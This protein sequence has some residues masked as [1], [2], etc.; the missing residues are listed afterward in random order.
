[1]LGVSFLL[2][3]NA[4]AVDFPL[5]WRWSN[6][7]PHGGNVFDMDYAPLQSLGVQVCEN[8]QIYVSHDLDLWLPRDTFLTNFLRAVTFLG[9]RVIITGESGIV[10][11]SNDGESFQAGALAD[12]LTTDWLEAVTASASLAVAVGDNGAVYTSANG[13]T[14]K[15]Q[16][17]GTTANLRGVAAGAGFF[18][19]VGE[20]GNIRSSA[21]GTNWTARS[22]PTSAH[23][24][25]VGFGNS[26]FTSVGDGGVT[27]ASTNAGLTWFL[28]SPGATNDLQY[29][30]VGGTNRLLD[31]TSEVRVQDGG[32]WSNELAKTN[33]PPDWTY[34][35]A[36][37][38]PGFF[39]I[40]GRSGMQAEGYQT[41][42]DP[43]FWLTPHSSVRNWLWDVIRLPS[44]YA[45]V[46]DFGTIMTSGGGVDWTLE[47]PPSGV[48]DNTLLG[49]GGTTNLL[50]AVGDTGTIIYSPNTVTNIITTNSTGTVTQSMSTLGVVWYEA[51]SL[52]T[53]TLQ[54]VGV[55]NH[56]LLVVTGGRGTIRTSTDGLIWQVVTSPTTNL[57][58]GVAGW[59]NGLVAVG[60]NGTVLTSSDGKSWSQRS[61]GTTNWIY[62]VRWLNGTLVAVGQ[63]GAILTSTNGT[64]W[65]AR[66]SGTSFWLTDA[67]F[68]Q[69][70]WF[71]VGLN[72]TVLA[73]SN[74]V[75]WAA[76]G[77]LTR[78][79]LYG[80]AADSKQLVVVGVEGAILRSQIVP[81][82]TPVSF[83]GYSLV[84]TNG[85]SSAYNI[86]LFGG[87]TDQ[88]FTLDRATNLV[89]RTWAGGPELE[90]F[91]GSGTLYYVETISGTN[92]P[93]AEYY[94]TALR[95]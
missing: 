2:K 74:L 3:T 75:N 58:S 15:R 41:N 72:G 52:T 36:I 28:E 22:S 95:P 5:R 29:A 31:G 65:T 86:F 40:A 55:L 89:E 94:R 60:D 42:G 81:E 7:L 16:T 34:Y 38:R 51:P 25:R 35:T 68:I 90:I 19:A 83:L 49:I 57:L 84:P 30:A 53:E 14:W 33:G 79:G 45:A 61:V 47:L 27:I 20:N 9:T 93:P 1:M 69:D 85:H 24:N 87:V 64:N 78:K 63:N 91:D 4:P 12:G 39:L 71:A 10:L 59:T 13:Q 48:S 82:T 6:P 11:Y 62:R 26:R 8:G 37:G 88:R 76:P 23:L 17:S 32:V 46:G 70:T 21:N 77:T 50:V 54:G 43:Y 44:L 80:V 18:I 92:L 67:T 66:A 73:S 56:S